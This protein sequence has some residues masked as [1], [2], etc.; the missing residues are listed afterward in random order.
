MFVTDR[1]ETLGDKETRRML[2][3][4]KVIVEKLYPAKVE[5]NG[6]VIT[7]RDPTDETRRF[8]KSSSNVVS[9]R[10]FQNRQKEMSE[11][12]ETEQREAERR[13]GRYSDVF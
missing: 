7:F 4:L 6:W 3:A 12:F 2:L 9:K 5:I 13:T 10:L 8:D 11:R 1:E